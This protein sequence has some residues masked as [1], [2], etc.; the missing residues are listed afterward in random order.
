MQLGIQ[1]LMGIV[2]ELQ[3]KVTCAE[4]NIEKNAT[5]IEQQ[6]LRVNL[7]ENKVETLVKENGNKELINAAVAEK[8][9]EWS[10]ELQDRESRKGHLIVHNVREPGPECSLPLKRKEFDL[11]HIMEL[12]NI[13]EVECCV[14]TEVKFVNRVGEKPKDGKPRPMII[15]FRDVSIRD[16]ILKNT[17]KLK[18]SSFSHIR[19]VPD[20]TKLQ[21][22]EE[23]ELTEEATQRNNNMSEPESLNFEWRLVGQKGAKRLQKVKKLKRPRQTSP[24]QRNTRPRTENPPGVDQTP[25]EN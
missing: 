1:K 12:C 18:N 5:N 4:G 17:F 16:S 8:S 11:D 13:T 21:R 19:I 14:D 20:L 10:R 22:N 6:G 3:K 2:T 24:P 9:R 7:L 15:G 23:Q 25:M